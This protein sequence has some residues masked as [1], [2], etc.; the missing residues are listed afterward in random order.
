MI[1]NSKE[2]TDCQRMTGSALARAYQ[3]LNA[4]AEYANP[5]AFDMDMCLATR[6]LYFAFYTWVIL[7][8]KIDQ[9][10]E[11]DLH[12]IFAAAM[13]GMNDNEYRDSVEKRFREF[14]N[15]C[16]SVRKGVPVERSTVYSSIT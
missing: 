4:R 1:S 8:G 6:S 14:Q 11:E 12:K 3:V 2:Q 10:A 16:H 9:A 5:L 15:K 13:G 7:H